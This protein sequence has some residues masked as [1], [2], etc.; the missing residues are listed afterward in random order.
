MQ[1][2]PSIKTLLERCVSSCPTV[3][4]NTCGIDSATSG[5][6]IYQPSSTQSGQPSLHPSSQPTGWSSGYP[7]ITP[8]GHP[9]STSPG[10]TSVTPTSYVEV[11]AQKSSEASNYSAYIILTVL[12]VFTGIAYAVCIRMCP[13]TVKV[14]PVDDRNDIHSI[15][16]P[17][18]SFLGLSDADNESN[19][20]S[21]KESVISTENAY[22]GYESMHKESERMELGITSPAIIANTQAKPCNI[23]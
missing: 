22:M 13:K 6:P 21:T 4:N 11:L 15:E 8:T 7:T 23:L 5:Q 1:R 2:H 14:V 20:G 9:S 19:S 18:Q 16:M 3:E 10:Q 17:V 12:C